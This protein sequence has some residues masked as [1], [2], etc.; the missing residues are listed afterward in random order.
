[1]SCAQRRLKTLAGNFVQIRSEN[2]VSII[3]P[4]AVESPPP[5][6]HTRKGGKT[7]TNAHVCKWK[8]RK[9]SLLLPFSLLQFPPPQPIHH[10]LIKESVLQK[11]SD[12]PC[13]IPNY[14]F[15]LSA[16]SCVRVWIYRPISVSCLC[17]YPHLE[18]VLYRHA[19]QINEMSCAIGLFSRFPFT[20]FR[21]VQ[22]YESLCDEGHHV[23]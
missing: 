8:L 3:F 19:T 5:H 4:V 1:M 6:T 22:V 17:V 2:C 9:T 12:A 21:L 15:F 10:H 14:W 20:D 7:E 11:N 23:V 13:P 18:V 16:V